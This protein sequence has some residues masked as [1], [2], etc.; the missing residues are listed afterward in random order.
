MAEILVKINDRQS[1]EELR[2]SPDGYDIMPDVLGNA[3][4]ETVQP[5]IEQGSTE[6]YFTMDHIDYGLWCEWIREQEGSRLF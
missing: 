3:G 5:F 6:S 2:Y 4:V 1:F